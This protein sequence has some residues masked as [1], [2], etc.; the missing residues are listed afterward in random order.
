MRPAISV[1]NYT[2]RWYAGHDI[3]ALM[4][5]YKSFPYIEMWKV[6]RIDYLPYFSDG[7]LYC[8]PMFLQN[9]K[10]HKESWL[11]IL[12][13]LRPAKNVFVKN[14]F[15]DMYFSKINLAGTR[16]LY[17]ILELSWLDKTFLEICETSISRWLH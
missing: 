17:G 2:S 3:S 5:F 15:L 16:C 6:F 10:K 9:C 14:D 4:A 1:D 13:C 12:A 7:N 8:L 11:M